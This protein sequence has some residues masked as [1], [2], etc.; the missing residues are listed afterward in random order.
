MATIVVVCRL[1][2][3]NVVETAGREAEYSSP[4]SV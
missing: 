1:T 3:S 4:T 2:I